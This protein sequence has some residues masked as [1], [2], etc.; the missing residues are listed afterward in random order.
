MKIGNKIV[1]KPVKHG[2]RVI[3]YIPA[4]VRDGMSDFYTCEKDDQGRI[5][6]TPFSFKE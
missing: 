3:I 1:L 4:S 5:I 2:H 6:Y